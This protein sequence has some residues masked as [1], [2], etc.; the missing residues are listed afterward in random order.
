MFKT[1]NNYPI[2][3][4]SEI[5]EW[6]IKSANASIM[7][8]YKLADSS[9]LDKVD[10]LPKDRRNIYVGNMM[11]N[12]KNFSLKLE[13]AFNE[14]VEIFMKQNNLLE[15]DIVSIKRDAVFVKNHKITYDTIG[16]YI[17]FR[18]KNAY[19]AFLLL[20]RKEFYFSLK[21]NHIDIKGMNDETLKKHNNGILIFI[22]QVIELL[23][24]ENK[25]SLHAYLREFVDAYKMR[26]LPFDYYRHFDDNSKYIMYI[27]LGNDEKEWIEVSEI[28][29]SMINYISI[30][31]NY[32]NI[33]L[34]LIQLV[35]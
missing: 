20:D 31:Y 19:H 12:D 25:S 17:K 13:S 26:E 35:L 18:P 15:S 3:V 5:I 4:N 14:V 33:I 7:R 30:K 32:E 34:P 24:N 16:N 2:L 10:S 29:D 23:E 8:E 22:N 1:N 21:D 9:I 27:D 6:D 28:D 11:R